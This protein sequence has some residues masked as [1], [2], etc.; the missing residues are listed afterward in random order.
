MAHRSSNNTYAPYRDWNKKAVCLR[1]STLIGFFQLY[2]GYLLLGGCL[3][4]SAE[5]VVPPGL[6]LRHP[7]I[8]NEDPQRR[9]HWENRQEGEADER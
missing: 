7:T 4:C 9:K 3:F 5:Q 1:C 8:V 6:S 2:V